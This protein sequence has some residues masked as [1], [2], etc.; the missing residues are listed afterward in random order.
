MT[1]RRAETETAPC[2]ARLLHSSLLSTRSG[3]RG[4][5]RACRRVSSGSRR[6]R[7]SSLTRRDS[8]DD[9]RP[10]GAAARC[11]DIDSRMAVLCVCCELCVVPCRRPLR[12]AVGR[13]VLRSVVERMAFLRCVD[14]VCDGCKSEDVRLTAPYRVGAVDTVC[15]AQFRGSRRNTTCP[16][17]V[18]THSSQSHSSH[19]SRLR[20]ALSVSPTSSS[21][22]VAPSH[23]LLLHR[24]HS[25]P[26]SSSC[27]QNALSPNLLSQRINLQ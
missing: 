18:Q 7:R 16:R 11:S 25:S 1:Q 14:G 19:S 23:S 24:S 22:G 6:A 9:K 5:H 13:A 10:A 20:P 4:M 17:H 15:G 12:S 27:L 3:A 8:G 26:S 2:A 21:H